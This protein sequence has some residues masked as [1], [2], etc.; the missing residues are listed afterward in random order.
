MSSDPKIDNVDTPKVIGQGSYGCVHKPQM[1]CKNKTQKKNNVSKLMKKN[2]AVNELHEYGYI[3]AADK[4]HN[5]YLGKP[6][7]CDIEETD[8]NR[9][10]IQD[11]NNEMFVSSKLQDYALLVMNDGGQNLEQFANDVYNNWQDTPENRNKIELFWLEVSRLFYG[12][13]I[14]H[15]HNIVHHD[16]KPQNIVYDGTSNRLNFIDFGFMTP[17]SKL[18]HDTVHSTYWSKTHHWSFPWENI[19]MNRRR[20]INMMDNMSF[21]RNKVFNN[22]ATSVTSNCEVF[23]HFI[24]SPT[25]DRKNK[26]YMR[27]GLLE[28]YY[29]M[30][31]ELTYDDYARFVNKSIDTTDSYGVGIA[32]SYVLHRTRKF[33]SDDLYSELGDLFANMT[34][35][36]MFNRYDVDLLLLEYE[37]IMRESKLLEKHNMRYEN[38]ILVKGNQIPAKVLHH[39]DKLANLEYTLTPEQ[40]TNEA[41]EYNHLCP[42]GKMYKPTTKRCI[43]ICKDGY[44]RDANF[45]CVKDKYNYVYVPCPADK[46]RNPL[47]RRC[48]KKC[49]SGYLRDKTYKCKKGSDPFE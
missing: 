13:Q 25:I 45:K 34:T 47:T 39:I 16:L 42:D 41:L 24:I 15:K 31:S 9:K 33:I 26:S 19:Y 14:F 38:H 37:N 21:N 35:P 44:V 28:Q 3:D 11:C 46:D 40:L 30:L 49:K 36:N 27:A 12:L 48:V 2:S 8:T 20:Y 32:L 18:I 1:K 4:N 7:M 29:I 43:K 17:V 5:L 6:I 23:F 10:A 22:D